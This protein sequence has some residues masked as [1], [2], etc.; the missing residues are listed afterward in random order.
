MKYNNTELLRKSHPRTMAAAPHLLSPP[1]PGGRGY[2]S[3]P[4]AEAA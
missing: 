3:S 1:P 2:F 4:A